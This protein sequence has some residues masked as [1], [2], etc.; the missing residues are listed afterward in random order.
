[1]K[2]RRRS[3]RE[4]GPAVLP[5]SVFFCSPAVSDSTTLYPLLPQGVGTAEVESLLNYYL[6]LA[7]AHLLAPG[8]LF[9]DIVAPYISITSGRRAIFPPGGRRLSAAVGPTSGTRDLVASLNALCGRTDLEALT[10]LRWRSFVVG[11]GLIS[12]TLRYCAACL[13]EDLGSGGAPYLR[14]AWHLAPFTCCPRHRLVLVES[15]CGHVDAR[16]YGAQ[17]PV[18]LGG[19][20]PQ[21]GA[22]G[23]GCRASRAVTASEDAIWVSGQISNAIAASSTLGSETPL[24]LKDAVRELASG[25]PRGLSGVAADSNLPKSLLW[26]WIQLPE[27]RLSLHGL[28]QICASQKLDLGGLLRGQLVHS[29]CCPASVQPSKRRVPHR[30]SKERARTVLEECLSNGLNMALAS[31]M[32]GVSGRQLRTIFPDLTKRIIANSALLRAKKLEA[33]EDE[34]IALAEATL[35]ELRT[36]GLTATRRNAGMVTARPWFPSQRESLCLTAFRQELL[37]D[38]TR[39][40]W[41]RRAV[42]RFVRKVEDAIRRI[43]Q[44]GSLQGVPMTPSG[45]VLGSSRNG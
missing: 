28:L 39:S 45:T 42:G 24:K 8:I 15:E 3:R 36:Q 37:C 25:H 33:I 1:M 10:F 31:K 21:C 9:R 14:L 23:Y 7:H 41:R 43:A 18:L 12:R 38:G 20:C 27:S 34:A 29:S 35:L 13:L 6:K 30:V 19:H 22:I 16:V 26:R 32:A 2:T 11:N 4:W 5:E 44:G 17:R 40:N